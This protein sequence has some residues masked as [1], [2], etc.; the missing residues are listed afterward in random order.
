MATGSVN[1]TAGTPHPGDRS[2]RIPAL[3]YLPPESGIRVIDLRIGLVGD[4]QTRAE[5]IE[6]LL[7]QTDAEQGLDPNKKLELV[8]RLGQEVVGAGLVGALKITDLVKRGDH[9]DDHISSGGIGLD[10]LADLEPRHSGHHHVQENEVRNFTL[11]RR[12]GLDAIGGGQDAAGKRLEIRLHQ[13]KILGVV[14]DQQDRRTFKF[15]GSDV[16]ESR[17]IRGFGRA[18]DGAAMAGVAGHGRGSPP[19]GG[20]TARRSAGEGGMA[21]MIEGR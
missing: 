6:L 18:G 11:D 3:S 14:V 8:H 1:H 5:G 4:A 12:H 13:L 20:R 21:V 19:R 17:W 16:E 2:R 15:R 10:L 9:D 7:E